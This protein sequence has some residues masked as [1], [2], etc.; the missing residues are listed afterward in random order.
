MEVHP[1]LRPAQG[2]PRAGV[3]PGVPDR[4]DPVRPA[5]RAAG[6]GRRPGRG[7][8]P[9]GEDDARLYGADPD[10]GVGGFGAF[11]LLLDEPEVYGL[12]PDPVAT[13]RHLAS[14]GA[15]PGRGRHDRPRRVAAVVGPGPG[16]PMRL[17]AA[18]ADMGG[19]RW[20]SEPPGTPA[21]GG[22][23]M[24]MVR[25]G[26]ERPRGDDADVG[27][28][29]ARRRL[30]PRER[31]TS[32]YG[33]PVI[34]PPPWKRPVIAELLLLRRS[35]GRVG[36]ARRRRRTSRRAA[37]RAARRPLAL[38]GL[39]VSPPLLIADLGRPDALPE[40]AARLQAHL[41]DERR[42]VDPRRDQRLRRR[43]PPGEPDRPAPALGR[44]APA[45]PAGL[46]SAPRWPPTPAACSPTPRSRRGT[47]RATS[48]RSSS[49]GSAMATP[50]ARRAG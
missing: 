11:F 16:P 18:A 23:T 45:L 29:A 36:G 7:L 17:R 19:L 26:A 10:D 46:P 22:P 38:A 43:R 48:S 44:A 5:R 20:G 14:S 15:P 41:A 27:R 42:L 49:P 4:F 40:H 35:R 32:Y 30:V 39:A 25:R 33:R 2:R 12:P 21:T 24:A 47:R 37:A 8:R 28:A 9:A 50:A 34:K 13:T 6:P 31:P 3:R 1:L